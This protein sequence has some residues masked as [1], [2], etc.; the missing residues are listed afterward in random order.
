MAF[1]R[2]RNPQLPPWQFGMRHQERRRR[3]ERAKARERSH[4]HDGRKKFRFNGLRSIPKEILA[5]NEAKIEAGF[6]TPPEARGGRRPFDLGSWWVS[7]WWLT[8][9]EAAKADSRPRRAVRRNL[10]G[11]SEGTVF[12]PSRGKPNRAE[13]RRNNFPE[14][15]FG[16]GGPGGPPGRLHPQPDSSGRAARTT[17]SEFIKIGKLFRRRSSGQLPPRGGKAVVAG[18]P[19]GGLDRSRP[20]R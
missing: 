19:R 15:R 20:P 6:V 14:T 16:N 10:A 8:L 13:R 18:V 3:A 17:G 11:P 4:A 7:D 1:G 5:A 12:P 2:R 9:A